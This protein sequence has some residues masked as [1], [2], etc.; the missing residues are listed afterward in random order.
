MSRIVPGKINEN[1]QLDAFGRLRTSTS[2]QRFDVEFIYNKQPD[3]VDEVIG[4]AGTAVFDANARDVNLAVNAATT[5]DKAELYSYDVPYTP[6]NSQVIDITGVL[7]YAGIGGGDAEIFFRSNITGSVVETTYPQS[8]WLALRSGVDWSYSH[9]FQMDFQSLKV[10]RIRFQ[11]VQDGIPVTVQQIVNDNR[12][13]TGYWQLPSLPVHWRLY[14]DATYTYAEIGYGDSENAIGFRYKIPV[15]AN[16]E[17]KAICSTV[18]SEGG[19]ELFN[20]PGFERT[21]NMGVTELAVSTTLIP[22]ISLRAATTFN[23]QNFRG[24]IIPKDFTVIGDNPMRIDIISGNTLTGASWTPVTNSAAEFDVTATATTGGTTVF[25][26]YLD[27]GRNQPQSVK[28]LLD[29]ALL[30]NRRNTTALPRN[31]TIAGIRTST[32]DSSTIASIN[33]AEIR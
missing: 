25:S 12:I 18:R 19:Q 1:F 28:N 14:N 3:I 27:S 20:I 7:D 32:S 13:N 9:I 5:S 26:E 6:G 29:R 33:W 10:G 15:N 4:G 2:G 24:L 11:M 23:S 22:I 21:A 31:L 30:W 16:A 8:G 17:M